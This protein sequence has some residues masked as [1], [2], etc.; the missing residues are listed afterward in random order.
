LSNIPNGESLDLSFAQHQSVGE[1]ERRFVLGGRAGAIRITA[2]DSYARLGL[3]TDALA[4]GAAT[5]TVP[6]VSLVRQFA[7]RNGVSFNA[8]LSLADDAGMFVRGGVASG[9]VEADEFTDVD[10]TVAAGLS[11]GGAH[12]HR[13]QDKMGVAV[14]LNDIS[15]TRAR[16]LAAGGLGVLVGDGSLPRKGAEAIGEAYYSA[17]LRSWAHLTGDIQII[18]NPAYNAT[19]GPVLVFG[20]RLHIAK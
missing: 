2:Y 14:V 1:V 12:W 4:H 9:D 17:A 8:E 5:G 6:D 7:H 19:R 15:A 18:G 10:R 13:A 20:L 11:L 16:Y 3:L